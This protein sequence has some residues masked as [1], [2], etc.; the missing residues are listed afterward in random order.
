MK[1]L[2]VQRVTSALASWEPTIW[3]TVDRLVQSIQRTGWRIGR[4]RMT[5]SLVGFGSNELHVS[6]HSGFAYANPPN[7][8]T[9]ERTGQNSQNITSG[10]NG[11]AD[12]SLMWG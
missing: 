2:L 1:N 4:L 7:S 12:L 9:G 11:Q 8:R 10:F 6:S 3:A 5:S